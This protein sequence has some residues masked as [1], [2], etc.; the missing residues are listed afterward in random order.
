M[1]YASI[2]QAL[3]AL[4]FVIGLIGVF[5]LVAKRMG[6]GVPSPALG[7]KNK[8]VVVLEVTPVDAKRRLVLFRRDDQEHLV[9]L[10]MN[11]EHVVE[12]NIQSTQSFPDTLEAL[13]ARNKSV[14]LVNDVTGKTT[15]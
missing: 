6:L 10:G 14:E 1:D 2:A 7:N 9:L 15:P 13:E 12:S 4:V 5:A 11:G 3:L 8:R